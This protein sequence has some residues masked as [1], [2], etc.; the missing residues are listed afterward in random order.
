MSMKENGFSR[1]SLMVL[2]ALGTASC[3]FEPVYAPAS[4]T[5][6]AL[7]D[8]VV[9]PPNNYRASYIFVREM[10]DRLGRNLNGGKI[11]EHDVWVY[12]DNPGF[13]SS[14][15]RIRRVGKITYKVLSAED[16]RLLFSGSVENFVTF[17]V[18]SVVTTSVV[19]EATDRLVIILVDQMTAQ[20]TARLFNPATE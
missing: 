18:D 2:L 14:G 19:A 15:G 9:A 6:A 10:E 17:V 13:L 11:L 20:L 4:K 5:A 7:S 8:I 1:F 16:G 12:D 3:G